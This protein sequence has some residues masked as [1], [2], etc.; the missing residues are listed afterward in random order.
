MASL[1]KNG[2]GS[3]IIQHKPV[4]KLPQWLQEPMVFIGLKL[5][6]NSQLPP[7]YVLKKGSISPNIGQKSCGI[8]HKKY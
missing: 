8:N 7:I 6:T 2:L 4:L 1:H 5:V 3:I